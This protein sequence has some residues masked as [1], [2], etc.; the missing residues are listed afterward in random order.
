MDFANLEQTTTASTSRKRNH[1]AHF[2]E[3]GGS[4][5]AFVP[6]DAVNTSLYA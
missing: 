2:F 6:E 1:P 3:R 4:G 5:H